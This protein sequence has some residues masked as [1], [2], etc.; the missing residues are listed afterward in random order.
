MAAATIERPTY[1]KEKPYVETR[2]LLHRIHWVH[3]IILSLTPVLLFYGLLTTKIIPKTVL[4]TAIYY[5]FGGL[6]ITA[7]YHR[8]WAHCGY[9]ARYPLQVFLALAGS[10][11]VQG[12]IFWWCRDHRVHHRYTDTN[13]DPYNA[14]RGLLHCHIGWMLVKKD[15]R[16]LGYADTS[17]LKSDPLVRW[18]HKYYP[19]LALL[20]GIIV[21]T[22]IPGLLWGDWRGGYF[23]ASIGRIVAVHHATFCINSL[24]HALGEQTYDDEQTARDSFVT[25][26]VTLGEGYH[27][28]HHQFPNDY[29][30]AIRFYQYDPTKWFILASK[31]LGLAYDL[32]TFPSNEITKGYLDMRL[33]NIRKEQAKLNYGPPVEKLPV[34]SAEEFL[35]QVRKCSK[36]WMVIEGCIYDVKDFTSRHPGGKGLLNS[37][38]GKDMTE[39]FNGGV[40]KHHN[41]ARNLLWT[42]RVGR[43]EET[44]APNSPTS[45]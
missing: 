7:G 11:S 41:A 18:Q 30:N 9:S 13:K 3:V 8:L 22:C 39:A 2:P 45:A 25:A 16:S 38:I 37:G 36:Q 4:F 1:P 24:A 6:G 42:M 17:D 19:L 31:N 5:V 43:I 27:N 29:R 33:K 26:I 28:F 35:H 34:Y 10:A 21:P 23:Y 40:Y 32:K 15:R 14:T 44:P 20:M 12:S